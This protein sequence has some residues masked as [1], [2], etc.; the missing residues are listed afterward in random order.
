MKKSPSGKQ[1]V[2]AGND[3][4]LD[5]VNTEVVQGGRRVDLID[6]FAALVTWLR[7]AGRLSASEASEAIRRWGG[8]PEGDFALARARALRSVLREMVS[9]IAAGAP[10][11]QT[12]VD[13]INQLLRRRLG[14]SQVIRLGE[15][16][17]QAFHAEPG[18]PTDLLVPVAE[19]A[20]HLICD[21]D[22]SLIKA[23]GNARCILYFYDSTKNHARRWCNMATCGNRMKGAA[24]QQRRRIRGL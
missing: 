20:A 2:W 12:A 16:Y 10:V 13:E 5:F 15:G 17:Q 22:F 23:C 21:R 4:C 9:G 8:T 1:F 6:D 18:E 11:G 3:L 19:A 14:S 7:E 24:H